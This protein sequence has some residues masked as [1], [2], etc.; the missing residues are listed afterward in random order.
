MKSTLM[1]AGALG[2][3]LAGGMSGALAAP[4]WSKV[5]AKKVTL[6][7]PGVASIERM[8]SGA[9]HDGS[10]GVKKN[11]A[12]AGCHEDG[13]SDLAVKVST[14]DTTIPK[15]KPAMI[16]V[17]VQAAHDA[18]NLYLR[19]QWKAPAS[20]GGKKMDP[21]NQ[22]KLAVMLEDNKV[23]YARLGGCW[24]TC[25]NDLRTMPD[26]SPNA[27]KNPKAVAL[28]WGDGATKYVKESRT[29]LE[30]KKSPRG[31]WDK[32]KT[33]ADIEAALK[34]G[35][36]LDLM[37]YRSAKGA[38]P[39]DGYVL[40][41]RHMNGGKSLISAEG[42]NDGGNWTVTFTRKL[43]AGGP[44][45]HAIEPGKLYNI[46]FA[47]HDDYA[48]ARFHHVSFGYTMGLDNAKADIQV[49]KQ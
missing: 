3:C 27:A 35:K 36:F 5:P 44:G 7:Y 16:P 6:I 9:D 1:A 47:I 46:G 11:E 49:V 41:A 37:Q 8:L 17:T 14:A 29:A 26:A 32:L 13:A 22:V 20:S 40:E 15:G 23:E 2:L 42:K 19:F 39:V 12:C 4:D 30:L 33:D 18:S 45:D 10:N 43:A 48:N 25:H 34:A 28:G 31:G 21:D 38:K 24:A